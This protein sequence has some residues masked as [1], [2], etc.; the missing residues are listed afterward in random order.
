[1]SSRGVIYWLRRSVSRLALIEQLVALY[2]RTGNLWADYRFAGL[3]L[4]TRSRD[5]ALRTVMSN[6]FGFG[7]TNASLVLRR[8]DA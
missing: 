2:E 1:M 3:P 6:S 4:A 5:A 8:W 7:G